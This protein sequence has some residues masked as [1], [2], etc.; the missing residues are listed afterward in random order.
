MNVPARRAPSPALTRE[1]ARKSIH[2]TSSSVPTL[3]ALG[4]A[5]RLVERVLVV[6]CAVAVSLEVARRQSP[7]F[8][9]LFTRLFSP[10]LRAHEHTRTTGATW[11]LGAMLAAVLLLPRDIAIA[12]TWAVAV[13]DA[14]AAIVGMHVGRHRVQPAPKSFEGSAACMLA[15]MFGALLL[16]RMS[17]AESILLGVVAAVAERLPRPWDD[18][19]RIVVAVGATAW[20]WRAVSY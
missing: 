19:A 10:L 1:L 15:S 11:L 17:L 7:R 2:L 14:S 8:A 4:A 13:G 6:C 3:L 12:A 16:A 9:H 18:N 5:H 20:V